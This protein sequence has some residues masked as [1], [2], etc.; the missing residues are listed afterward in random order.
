MGTVHNCPVCGSPH[1]TA[2]LFNTYK[3]DSC[4]TTFKLKESLNVDFST[5]DIYKKTISSILEINTIV[6]GEEQFGT[7]IVVSDKGHILTCAHL[8]S[9]STENE[10]K[11]KN[12]CDAIV[13]KGKTNEKI[14]KTELISSDKILDLALLYSEE[15]KKYPPIVI[16]NV[17]IKTG[18]HIC[19]IGNSKG[20]GLCVVDGIISDSCRIVGTND[21]IVISAPVTSG[22]SGGPVFNAK[23]EV[24]GIIKGGRDGAVAMNY[25]ISSSIIKSFFKKYSL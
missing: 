25:A 18:E 23:G 24:I 14:I 16:P 5:S 22:Y 21:Y 9:N 15:A 19:A 6:N 11:V 8:L 7:G 13:A 20:E 3:C 2:K 10:S 17:Y 4:D 12:F 1:T